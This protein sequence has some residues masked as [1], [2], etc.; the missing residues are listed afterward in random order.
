MN[1]KSLFMACLAIAVT[2]LSGVGPP[3]AQAVDEAKIPHYF[4]PYPNWALSPL[5]VVNPAD[6]TVS[7]GI[8]K[9]VDTLPLLGPAGANNLGH[10]LPVAVPDTTSY[11]GSD[12]YE[13]GLVQ[14]RKKMHS[15]LPATLLRGYVQLSTAAVPGA[16][17]SLSNALLDGSSAP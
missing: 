14:Y 17:A 2:A 13:I 15:D 10:Y 6:G 1:R 3:A 7:G 16:G 12:Y 4:G 5:P 11:P 9:F 8:R